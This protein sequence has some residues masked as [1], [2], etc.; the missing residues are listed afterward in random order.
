MWQEWNVT[1]AS[2]LFRWRQLVQPAGSSWRKNAMST[3]RYRRQII[4]KW[5]H[6]LNGQRSKVF[7]IHKNVFKQIYWPVSFMPVWLTHQTRY[8][9]ISLPAICHLPA[10]IVRMQSRTSDCKL[11]VWTLL[12]LTGQFEGGVLADRSVTTG[13]NV[14]NW[15]SDHSIVALGKRFQ[16][17]FL[18]INVECVGQL[19]WELKSHCCLLSAAGWQIS[20]CTLPLSF[21]LRCSPHFCPAVSNLNGFLHPTAPPQGK[22]E[23]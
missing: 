19:L 5:T 18:V 10:T 13:T 7:P 20:T 15:T 9:T 3:S 22:R 8:L 2:R 4:V 6:L 11:K 23:D 12:L 14:V 16:I 21:N 1:Q 17:R